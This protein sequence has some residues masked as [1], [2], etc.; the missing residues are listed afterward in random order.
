MH[1]P[2]CVPVCVD[3]FPHEII[4]RCKLDIV[5]YLF[6]HFFEAGLLLDLVLTVYSRLASPMAPEPACLYLPALGLQTYI[7]MLGILLWV[8][9]IILWRQAL[10]LLSP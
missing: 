3:M 6:P 8:L 9:G 4:H 10:F 5:F 1:G 7:T 2:V